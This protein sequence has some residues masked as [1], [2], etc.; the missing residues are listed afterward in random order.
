MRIKKSVILWFFLLAYLTDFAQKKDWEGYIIDV[1]VK[2]YPFMNKIADYI[3]ST[4]LF[5]TTEEE[6]AEY[7]NKNNE[8]YELSISIYN[9]NTGNLV[10]K[11]YQQ[12]EYCIHI[13]SGGFIW[14]ENYRFR[15]NGLTFTSYDDLSPYFTSCN[16]SKK[17]RNKLLYTGE[18]PT[19]VFEVRNSKIINAFYISMDA[20][21]VANSLC[22]YNLNTGEV[23]K[24][25]E[26]REK[27]P[28][29]Y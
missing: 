22:V 14:D 15:I 6:R 25:N 11:F 9:L 23:L 16:I 5:I 24:F 7:K 10:K 8:F 13:T 19:W 28:D 26:F 3:K 18:D 21:R 27:Y 17:I 1:S 2:N 4:D 12:G 20:W 29:L